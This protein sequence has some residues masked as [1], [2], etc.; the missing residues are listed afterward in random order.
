LLHGYDNF[1][2]L[3]VGLHVVVRFDD[4]R[5]GKDAVNARLKVARLDVIENILLRL[6][7]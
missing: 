7:P 1:A 4:L 5:K 2:N 6:G 3:L